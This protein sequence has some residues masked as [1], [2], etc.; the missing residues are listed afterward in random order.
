MRLALFF[1][2][3]TQMWMNL[4]SS[5]EVQVAEDKLAARIKKEVEPLARLAPAKARIG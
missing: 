4:Q 5:Y 3:S 1:G 2:T